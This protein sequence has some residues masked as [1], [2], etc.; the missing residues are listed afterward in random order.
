MSEKKKIY[1]VFISPFD[2]LN[3]R[4]VSSV[5][6]GLSEIGEDEYEDY[7]LWMPT[8][9]AMYDLGGS[10]PLQDMDTRER[11]TNRRLRTALIFQSE[12]ELKVNMRQTVRNATLLGKEVKF[13]LI[14]S[15][16][17]QFVKKVGSVLYHEG[18]HYGIVDAFSDDKKD[19]VK[20]QE[21]KSGKVR[22]A[23]DS[24]SDGEGDGEK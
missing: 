3:K 17:R 8:D 24:E 19:F 13:L 4:K 15:D 2:V 11:Y 5:L 18:C 9:D 7:A 20:W 10:Y 21:R 14:A 1:V 23:G 12:T 16:P 22:G 6:K